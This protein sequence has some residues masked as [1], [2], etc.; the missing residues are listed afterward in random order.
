L[1][2]QRPGITQYHRARHHPIRQQ[3][4]NSPGASRLRR[5]AI[6]A[7]RDLLELRSRPQP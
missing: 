5:G 6:A 2:G 4:R 3:P 7:D 1:A